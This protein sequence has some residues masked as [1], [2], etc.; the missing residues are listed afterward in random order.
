M[1][2]FYAHK[3]SD[4][5]VFLDAEESAHCVRV[6]RHR[7]GDGIS[8]IADHTEKVTGMPYDESSAWN[9][10]TLYNCE[11]TDVSPKGVVARIESVQKGWGGHPYYLCMAVCPTKNIDRYEWFV[12]KAVELGVDEIVPVI[13]DHSERKTL[14]LDR[15]QRIAVSAAKQSLKGA[16]PVIAEPLSVCDFVRAE[17]RHLPPQDGA[18]DI[19]L[20]AYCS[21]DISPRSSIV[22]A[23]TEACAS[24]P[25]VTVLIGPEGDFSRDEVRTALDAGFT[26]VHLGPSRLRTET[27]AL[28]AVEAAYFALGLGIPAYDSE[29]PWRP[30]D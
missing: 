22:D 26:P 11:I 6:L 3:V 7:V 1:E 4:G 13:G 20:I 15:L 30:T 29:S 28:T 5:F 8:V 24:I 2:L 18:A 27:A 19:R 14:R 12:E 17:D 9:P 16:V 21:E 10:A 25:R 23:L